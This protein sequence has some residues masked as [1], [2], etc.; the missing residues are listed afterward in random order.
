MSEE[1]D[2]QLWLDRRQRDRDMAMERQHT[3]IAARC[4]KCKGDTGGVR[5]VC[6]NCCHY[7]EVTTDDAQRYGPSRLTLSQWDIV[8][9]E[10][11]QNGKRIWK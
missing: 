7:D 1:R 3:P 9:L 4:I 6:L 11:R 2:F 8:E 5:R 10:V